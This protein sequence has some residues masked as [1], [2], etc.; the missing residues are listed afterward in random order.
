MSSVSTRPFHNRSSVSGSK[1]IAALD[2]SDAGYPGFRGMG[3]EPEG[4]TANGNYFFHFPDGN[5]IHRAVADSQ[6]DP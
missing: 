4:L 6:I 2:A 1:P 3:I 5:A